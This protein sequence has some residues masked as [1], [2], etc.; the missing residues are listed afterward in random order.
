MII[1]TDA[2][3]TLSAI[4]AAGGSPQPLTTLEDGELVHRGVTILPGGRGILF[5]ALS[6]TLETARVVVQSSDAGER[7]V[8]VEGAHPRYVSTGHLLFARSNALW[9]VPFDLESLLVVGEP[10]PVVEDVRQEPVGAVQYAVAEDGTLAYVPS[11]NEGAR[12]TSLLWVDRDGA[13]TPLDVVPSDYQA[14]AISPSGRQIALEIEGDDGRDN[15][16]VV[17][18]ERGTLVPRTSGNTLNQNPVWAPDET[19]IA[20]SAYSRGGG[21]DLFL[22]TPSAG[23]EP[24]RL[25]SRDGLQVPTSWSSN[26]DLLAFNE[27]AP[28]NR[29]DVWILS[30][31]DGTASA[32]VATGASERDAVF[33][34]DSRW[35]AYASDD[36]GRPEVYLTTYPPA[37][38]VLVSTMGGRRPRWAPND[39]ELLYMTDN[40]EVMAVSVRASEDLEIGQPQRVFQLPGLV[41]FDVHPDGRRFVAIQSG[42]SGQSQE[43]NIVQNWTEE[44]KRLVPVN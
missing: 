28:G 13:F 16:W 29:L 24:Q 8:L 9:A 33:S 26:G 2:S 4:P 34:S 37:G 30:V 14:L 21:G 27:F 36:S 39:T 7:R 38:S 22:T 31:A 42:V 3:S 32:L 1:F 5:T 44:L 15:V 6:G 43:I 12:H 17:D 35:L 25:H 19:R 18:V 10:V 23:G 11:P 41:D 40:G 20:F